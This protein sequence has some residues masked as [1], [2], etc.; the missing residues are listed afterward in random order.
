MVIVFFGTPQFA[1]PSLEALV[2]SRHRVPL[3][4]TQPDKRRDRGQKVTDA[5]V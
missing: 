3:V 4:V 2:G 1:E 5:P